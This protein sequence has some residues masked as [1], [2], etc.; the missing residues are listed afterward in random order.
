MWG[1][2]F[3]SNTLTH[4][5]GTV[6]VTESWVINLIVISCG[7][8]VH[9]MALQDHKFQNR[10]LSQILTFRWNALLGAEL[11]SKIISVHNELNSCRDRII[12]VSGP[13][14]EFFG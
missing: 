11:Y 13:G 2:K 3:F 4:S 7:K 8:L 5:L 1:N 9:F 6:F 14:E 10:S 12:L